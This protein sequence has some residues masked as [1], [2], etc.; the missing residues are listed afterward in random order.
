MRILTALFGLAISTSTWAD[1]YYTYCRGVSAKGEIYEVYAN[2]GMSENPMDKES[3]FQM[4]MDRRAFLQVIVS[5]NNAAIYNDALFTND[6]Q[7]TKSEEK[8]VY[9]FGRLEVLKAG[10]LESATYKAQRKDYFIMT[11]MKD[12]THQF[13]F[14]LG[15]AYGTFN[16]GKCTTTQ[17]PE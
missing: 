1:T 9:E 8:I 2:Y 3:P 11:T 6:I 17:A 13:N 7:V 4:S 10:D 14:E 16:N 5:Q 12:K 15:T